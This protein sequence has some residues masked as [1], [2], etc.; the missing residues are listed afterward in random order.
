MFQEEES[1]QLLM[2]QECVLDIPKKTPKNY[3]K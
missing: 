2:T 1:L 3:L